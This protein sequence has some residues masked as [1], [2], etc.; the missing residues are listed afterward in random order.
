MKSRLL[1]GAVLLA[2]LVS[3]SFAYDRSFIT[4]DFMLVNSEE[5]RPTDT[6]SL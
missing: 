6:G 3:L 2:T 4:R 1:L 5:D